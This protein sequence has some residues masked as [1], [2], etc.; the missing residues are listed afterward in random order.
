M[1][2][3]LVAFIT[4]PQNKA[5]SIAFQLVEKKVCACVNIIDSVTSVYTWEGKVQK[6]SEALM[7]AKTNSTTWSSFESLVNEL[8]PYD[9]PEIISVP[10]ELGNQAYLDW[11]NKSL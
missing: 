11:L 8:H 2:K 4:C 10:I 3:E 9:V 5:E 1:S 6:D 7:I